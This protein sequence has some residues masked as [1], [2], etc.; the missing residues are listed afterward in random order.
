VGIALCHFE[1]VC[2]ELNITG[3]FEVLEAGKVPENKGDK[4]TISWLSF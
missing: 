4:Y 2:R 1:Q 3:K